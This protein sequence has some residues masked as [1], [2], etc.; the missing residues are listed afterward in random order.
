M[1]P[2]GIGGLGNMAGLM[3]Q[4]MEMKGKMEEIKAQMADEVV[5]ATAG[6]GMVTAAM[7]GRFELVSLTIEPEI[8]KQ[9]EAEMLETLVRAAVNECV[10]KI[11]ERLKE[12]MSELTGGM[13]IPGLTS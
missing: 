2:K 9:D 12:R 10:R 1:F 5:E 8:I 11:Q 7:S 4:A 6:G 3:K 13:D